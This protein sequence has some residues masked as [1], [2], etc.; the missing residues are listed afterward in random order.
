MDNKHIAVK[1][2]D[3]PGKVVLYPLFKKPGIDIVF[4]FL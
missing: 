2:R 4:C 1:G 3:D